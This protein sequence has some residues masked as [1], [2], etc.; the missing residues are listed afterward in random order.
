MTVEIVSKSHNLPDVLIG[1]HYLANTWMESY[2]HK[3]LIHNESI[4][5]NYC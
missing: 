3:Q 1:F 2:F 5:F 4:R